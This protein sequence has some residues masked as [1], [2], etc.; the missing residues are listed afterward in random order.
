MHGHRPISVI[1]AGIISAVPAKGI[2]CRFPLRTFKFR[3]SIL[4]NIIC[5]GLPSAVMQAVGSV[6]VTGMNL[7][8]SQ[9]GDAAITVMG[10]YSWNCK[11]L[12][13]CLVWY[14]S[15]CSA[16]PEASITVLLRSKPLYAGTALHPNPGTW[17]HWL[18]ELYSSSFL[19]S[20]WQ[21]SPWGR[22]YGAGHCIPRG[23]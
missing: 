14:E 4:T 12:R 7:I 18:L 20:W 2:N 1:A 3:P 10:I 17:L 21:S 16:D 9:F 19:N 6:M 13:L 11:A 15:G 8:L 22:N 23:F 5:I